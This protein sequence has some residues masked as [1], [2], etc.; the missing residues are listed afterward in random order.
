MWWLVLL[1]CSMSDDNPLSEER[2]RQQ[3]L[4]RFDLSHDGVID[5]QEWSRFAQQSSDWEQANTD[6]DHQVTA[7]EL[8]IWL[9]RAVPDRT[10]D[11]KLSPEARRA[12][13]AQT[14][15]QSRV[16]VDRSSAYPDV[17]A[18]P[19]RDGPPNLLL[20]SLD[21][22]RADHLSVY[23]YPKQ[24]TPFLSA[25]A[26]QGTVFDQA[27]SQSNESAWS[28]A[29]L[30]TGRYPS[31]IAR[32]AYETYA[33]PDD[34]LT[35]AGVLNNYSYQTAAF[36]GG[37]HVDESFGFGNGFETF[38]AE[39]GFA[40]LWHTA[41]KAA[42]WIAET[43]P[44]HPWFVFLHGYD[45]H[46]PYKGPGPFLHLFS[47][48]SGS[49][50]IEQL[51]ESSRRSE[52]V[53]NRVFYSSFEQ[54]WF[55][56]SGGTK[57][58]SPSTYSRLKELDPTKGTLLSDHE[59]DHLQSHYD[60]E[61]AY[62]DLQL[63]RFLGALQSRG[64]LENTLVVILS[65]HG[66]DLLDHEFVNH[67]TGLWDSCIRTPMIIVGPDIPAG[68]RHSGL[69]EARDVMPTLLAA[70]GAVAPAGLSGRSL[71][72]VIE[73]TEPALESVMAEGVMSMLALRTET[74]KLI[75]SD[76][77][78]TDPGHVAAL[79]RRVIDDG[80]FQL[81]DM[82]ADP[83]EK[84]NIIAEKTQ[85]NNALARQLR[86]KLVES[87]RTMTMGEHILSPSTVPDEVRQAMQ[88]AGYW[89]SEKEPPE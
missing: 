47:Q 49:A 83:D 72:G 33:V 77:D 7:E 15:G 79:E 4:A 21:T 34:A 61:L 69:V 24:T 36:V 3:T 86:R 53:Y 80:T 2:L 71:A 22:V 42:A 82:V 68:T 40:S 75:V 52:R 46:R 17:P 11:L 54:F 57:V 65:D 87:R 56:H 84:H 85:D 58:L 41:P 64:Q 55:E 6:G 9:D 19:P 73:G 44:E 29:T 37:G 32:P 78:L 43:D 16:L 23:G 51:S 30:F 13:Q 18:A 5:L 20:I 28:H 45:T 62:L 8:W 35:V 10:K 14:R 1:S 70:A 26:A 38:S 74:H 76:I 81:Y 48:G 60:G 59:V 67:R 31:E 63:A 89:P 50:L 39:D 88:D 12:K 66:E 25:F 27:M